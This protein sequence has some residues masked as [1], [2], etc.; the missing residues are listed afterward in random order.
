MLQTKS[1]RTTISQI[2]KTTEAQI[3]Q[4]T[5]MKCR[6]SVLLSNE[7]HFISAQDIL[8]AVVDATGIPIEAIKGRR[9]NME[10]K[11]A[12]H[13]AAYLLRT[14]CGLSYNRIKRE[15]GYKDHTSVIHSVRLIHSLLDTNDK[16]ISNKVFNCQLKI[17]ATQADH[18]AIA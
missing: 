11:E 14:E 6:V 12:R 10:I 5:G 15:V 8:Q 7:L 4:I 3:S 13:I 17:Y 1:Q 9:R 2:I 18:K 16:I